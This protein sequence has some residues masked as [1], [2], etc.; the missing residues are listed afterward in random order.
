MIVGTYPCCGKELKL[1]YSENPINVPGKFISETC[2]GC[3]VEV[4][5]MVSNFHPRSWVKEDYLKNN[6]KYCGSAIIASSGGVEQKIFIGGKL[7]EN[8]P[9]KE[10]KVGSKVIASGIFGRP[11]WWVVIDKKETNDDV[12]LYLEEFNA[13]STPKKEELCFLKE[14]MLKQETYDD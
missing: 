11:R 1:E 8:T 3:G 6:S 12:I 13:E 9:F 7:L 14:D 2:S 10:T 4:L 5:H